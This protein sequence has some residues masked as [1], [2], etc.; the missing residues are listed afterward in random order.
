M[1][2]Y[3]SPYRRMAAMREA[4]NR[5]FEDGIGESGTHEREMMLAVDVVADDEAYEIVALVPGLEADDVNIEVLNNTVTLRGEFKS[6]AEGDDKFLVDEL[7]AGR[8]SRVVTLPTAL[9][10][11]KAEASVKNG[12][13][14]LRIPKAE[15]HRPKSIKVVAA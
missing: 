2:I 6:T 8:F 14:H 11:S 3:I 15:A 1:T 13:L 12:V 5:M 9:D 4:M 10:P 7:P